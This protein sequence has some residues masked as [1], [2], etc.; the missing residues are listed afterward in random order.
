MMVKSG[1]KKKS[2]KSELFRKVRVTARK[3]LK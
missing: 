3:A 1:K 2:G